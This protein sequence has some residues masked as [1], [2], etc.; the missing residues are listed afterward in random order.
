MNNSTT[1]QTLRQSNRLLKMGYLLIG[2]F[3]VVGYALAQADP[4]DPDVPPVDIVNVDNTEQ[5]AGINH[6]RGFA[7]YVDD[8]GTINVVH[9]DGTVIVPNKKV[10]SHEYQKDQRNREFIIDRPANRRAP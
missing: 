10:Y 6:E 5:I 7:V 3:A 1:I 4:D 9:R 8:D 2:V